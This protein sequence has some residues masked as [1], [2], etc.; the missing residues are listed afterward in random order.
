[1][2]QGKSKRITAKSI[3]VSIRQMN[4]AVE[5]R[6]GTKPAVPKSCMDAI[7]TWKYA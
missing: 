7:R 4:A 5:K 2:K 6:Y 3:H 1:M